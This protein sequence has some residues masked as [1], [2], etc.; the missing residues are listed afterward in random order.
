MKMKKMN[1]MKIKMI[2]RVLTFVLLFTILVGCDGCYKPSFEYEA[3]DPGQLTA[4]TVALDS[5]EFREIYP[6]LEKYEDEVTIT[7]AVTQYDLESNVKVGT[8]PENQS[9]NKIAKDVLNINLKYV[10][11]GSSTT[12]DNK[13]NL[14]IASGKMP[15]MFY[16]SNVSLYSQLYEDGMLAD[17]SNVLWNLNDELLENYITYFPELLP[18][19]M[20]EGALYAFPAI[21]NNYTSAQ[22]LYIRQD[23]LDIVGMEAPTT[24]DEMVAVGQAFVDHKDEIASKTGIAENRVIPFT[25]NKELTWA[26]SYSCEGFFNSFGSSINSYFPDESG[27]LYYSNVSDSTKEALSVLSNMYSKGILDKEF[28]SKSAEQI[29]AN[30]KAGYVGMAFGEWWMAKDVLDDCVSNVDGANWTWVN[31]PSSSEGESYPIVDSV[32][33]S[34]YNVV[35]KTCEH[36]EAI[37]KLINL[38]YDIYYNDN[39]QQIFGNDVLP[40][41]GFYYQF[42]PVKLWDGIA[43]IREYKRVQEVFDNLY[44]ADFDPSEFIDATD[45]AENGLIQTVSKTEEGDYIVASNGSSYDIINRECIAEIMNNETW[46]SEFEK[47]RNREKILHFVDGYPYFVA[48]KAGKTIDEMSKGEKTGWG[49]YHEM[50][51]PEGGYA[52]VVELTEGKTEAKYDCF[53]GANLSSMVEYIEYINT[54]TNVIFTKIITGQIDIKDFEDEYVEKIFYGNGGNDIIEQVNAWYKAHSIDYDKIYELIK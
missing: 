21:T 2:G 20:D 8:T 44:N 28:L 29:Q 43:S 37:A 34:G 10:V 9:F 40:S 41:N 38:F 53:Y 31:L 5:E 35:S 23:W 27:S 50:I 51:D 42:V 22:R 25:I 45:Y 18:T 33:V 17:L 39:A 48:Y 7:V 19:C 30:I 47:L 49:I 1:I 11:V 12:Y 15:D 3:V 13:L 14:Y 52:Y 54:Q 26:G 4:P 36:P 6:T 16:T 24:I 46:K 32:A